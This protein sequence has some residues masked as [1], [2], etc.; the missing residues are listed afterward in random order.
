MEMIFF[1]C[2]SYHFVDFFGGY[3][4]VDVADITVA[5]VDALCRIFLA[6][7][8]AINQTKTSKICTCFLCTCIPSHHVLMLSH[9]I[10]SLVIQFRSLI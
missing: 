2:K 9:V 10:I 7:I 8:N 1:V 4:K 3:H 5:T 6:L